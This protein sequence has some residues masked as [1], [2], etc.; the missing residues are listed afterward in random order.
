M[1]GI[2]LTDECASVAT[3]AVAVL[4]EYK[5]RSRV[6]RSEEEESIDQPDRGRKGIRIGS[7]GDEGGRIGCRIVC[8]FK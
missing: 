7:E 8:V 4:A 1:G 6:R 3:A 5:S 2:G